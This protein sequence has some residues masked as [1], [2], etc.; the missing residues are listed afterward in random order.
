VST[1][2]VSAPDSDSASRYIPAWAEETVEKLK[3]KSIVFIMLKDYIRFLI[4]DTRSLVYDGNGEVVAAPG[5]FQLLSQFFYCF[6]LF[7]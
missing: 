7:T 3:A 1:A 6:T 5:K 4:W 2:L